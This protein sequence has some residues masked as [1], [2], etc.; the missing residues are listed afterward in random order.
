LSTSV[1]R[2]FTKCAAAAATVSKII[3]EVMYA[4]EFILA[5]DEIQVPFP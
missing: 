1:F 4:E 3:L 2:Y 5:C